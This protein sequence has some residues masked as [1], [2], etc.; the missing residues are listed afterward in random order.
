MAKASQTQSNA[1]TR[2]RGA[3]RPPSTKRQSTEKFS[4]MGIEYDNLESAFEVAKVRAIKCPFADILVIGSGGRFLGRCTFRTDGGTTNV[5]I[6]HWQFEKKEMRAAYVWWLSKN[7][8]LKPFEPNGPNAANMRRYIKEH[9]QA[10][11]QETGEDG[12][13]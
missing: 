8:K 7:C 9:V 4:V 2:Q 6:D 13:S 1:A 12:E 3:I 10:Y 11:K 5:L